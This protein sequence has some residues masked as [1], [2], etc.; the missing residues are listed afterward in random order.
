MDH[1]RYTED[2]KRIIL[3]EVEEHGLGVTV[4]K[5]GV[6]AKTVYRW[7]ERMQGSVQRKSLQET[8]NTAEMRR[9][10]GEVQQL[11]EIVAEKELALRIKDSLLKK[12]LLR[13]RTE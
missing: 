6:T 8:V 1:R 3:K 5:H 12:T 9:L 13:G 11:K 7:R 4:R 10:Q 2:E